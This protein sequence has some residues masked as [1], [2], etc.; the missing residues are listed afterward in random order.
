MGQSVVG[1]VLYSTLYLVRCVYHLINASISIKLMQVYR[2]YNL[3][4]ITLKLVGKQ[5]IWRTYT[6][7]LMVLLHSFSKMQLFLT[8]LSEKIYALVNIL[9]RKNMIRFVIFVASCQI[10]V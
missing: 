7:I 3:N 8:Q 4:M 5:L 6:L 2:N 9:T 10:L 1:K